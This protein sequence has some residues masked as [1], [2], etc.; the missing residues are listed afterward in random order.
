MMERTW[1]RW[2]QQA[3]SLFSGP[4]IRWGA[5]L[6]VLAMT[7]ALSA[8]STVSLQLLWLSLLLCVA[9]VMQWHDEP[10]ILRSLPRILQQQ[11][12]LAA[13]SQLCDVHQQM[14]EEL[15]RISNGRD[16]LFRALAD[17]QLQQLSRQLQI[18]GRGIVEYDCTEAWRVA[19]EQLLR[20]PGLYQYRSVSYVETQNYWQDGPGQQSTRLNIELQQA[21]IVIIERIVIVASHL[22]SPDAAFPE[23]PLHSWIDEQVRAGIK[24]QLVREPDL[25]NEPELLNDFGIYG[26]RAVGMQRVDATGR[27]TRFRLSFDFDDVCRAERCWEQLLLHARDYRT[28]TDLPYEAWQVDTH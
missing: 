20:S 15:I 16:H 10:S 27:T 3:V 4:A 28:G 12:Q 13:D 23:E 22:W 18:L 21:G 9:L 1:R 7:V 5:L 8:A 11:L 26:C 2:C 19:Y 6:L 14:S 17:V 24:I 25:A